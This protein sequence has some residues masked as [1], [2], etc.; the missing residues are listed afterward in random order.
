LVS[1]L[2]C[3]VAPLAGDPGRFGNW[4]PVDQIVEIVNLVSDDLGDGECM[5]TQDI[6]KGA[7]EQKTFHG[8]LRRTSCFQYRLLD[9]V[10]PRGASI[11]K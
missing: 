8:A 3:N 10:D 1:H 4:E 11:E 5:N 2:E 7:G 6:S 9:A